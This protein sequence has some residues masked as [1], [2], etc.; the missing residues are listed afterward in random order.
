MNS[1]QQDS[2][3]D[4]NV[5]QSSGKVGSSAHA[6]RR[7]TH[8]NYLTPSECLVFPDETYFGCF[9]FASAENHVAVTQACQVGWKVVARIITCS[10]DKA[11]LLFM[12]ALSPTITHS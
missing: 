3:L 11:P 5:I 8:E 4:T 9:F 7:I 10:T 6:R 12:H 1:Y 2:Q